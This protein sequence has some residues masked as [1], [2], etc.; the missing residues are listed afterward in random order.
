MIA[1]LIDRIRAWRLRRRPALWCMGRTQAVL[2]WEWSE[3][4]EPLRLPG[5]W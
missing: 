1:Y 4:Y 5:E 3:H 2:W